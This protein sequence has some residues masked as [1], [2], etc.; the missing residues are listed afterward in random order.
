M[1]KGQTAF[2]PLNGLIFQRFVGPCTV[3]AFAIAHDFDARERLIRSTLATA[4]LI[5]SNAD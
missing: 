2:E 4:Y 3:I 1:H 5:W